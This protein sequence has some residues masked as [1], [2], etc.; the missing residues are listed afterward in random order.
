MFHAEYRCA[1]QQDGQ[2]SYGYVTHPFCSPS[3]AALLT[4]RYQQ[5]FGREN[6]GTGTT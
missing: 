3:R 2:F 4:G 5:R 6:P 1:G